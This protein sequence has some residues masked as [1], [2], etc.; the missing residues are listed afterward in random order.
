MGA[1]EGKEQLDAYDELD[2]ETLRCYQVSCAPVASRV[3]CSI[4]SRAAHHPRWAQEFTLAT[5]IYYALL[6][7]Q[8]AEQSARMNAMENASKNAGAL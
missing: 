1:L 6:Q 2:S 8:A 3:G 4:L 7:A 5:N